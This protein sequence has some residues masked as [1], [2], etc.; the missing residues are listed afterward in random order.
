M[1]RSYFKNI[2][3]NANASNSFKSFSPDLASELRKRVEDGDP[4]ALGLLN[5]DEGS[6]EIEN[7]FRIPPPQVVKGKIGDEERTFYVIEGDIMVSEAEYKA[8][9]YVEELAQAGGAQG[10]L[11]TQKNFRWD[12]SVS[13]NLSWWLNSQ[14]FVKKGRNVE[15]VQHR[16]VLACSDWEKTCNVKFRQ[17]NTEAE[18]LFSVVYVEA[19]E[20]PG[21]ISFAQAFFPNSRSREERLLMIFPGFFLQSPN[22]SEEEVLG[23]KTGTLRHEIGHILGFRHEHIRRRDAPFGNEDF[24]RNP[25]IEEL[26]QYDSK[27]VMHYPYRDREGNLVGTHE[28]NISE[29]DAKGA[30]LKYGL[31]ASEVVSIKP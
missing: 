30:V 11:L 5:L 1:K 2:L 29:L 16:M 7:T 4:A 8:A 22:P 25:D 23:S 13:Q 24:G 15:D 12:V 26:T 19:E 3:A 21:T 10:F 20:E 17:V 31:P 14:S 18:A 6:K 28:M 9:Q 27:S